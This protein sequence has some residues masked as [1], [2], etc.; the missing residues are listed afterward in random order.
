MNSNK[1][2]HISD[3]HFYNSD[4]QKSR[5]D[6]LSHFEIKK[7]NLK[8][9]ST[10]IEEMNIGAILISGD[11]ELD[12]CDSLY[13]FL[14]EWRQRGAKVFI[15]FGEHD[16]KVIR[17]D[18]EAKTE[19]LQGIY[20]IEEHIVID[21]KS[22]GFYV[23][24]LSC[25]SKQKDF[26]EDLDKVTTHL[27]IKPGVFLAHP[28]NITVQKMKEIGCKYYAVGHIHSS[29]IESYG[30][31]FKGRPGHLYSL[32]D[33]NGKAWPAR[34]VVGEF[35]EDKLKLSLIDFPSPQTVRL[36][37]NPY[38]ADGDWIP[39]I[40][41]NCTLHASEQLSELIPGEWKDEGFR[42]VYNGYYNSETEK[43][44]G[45]VREILKIFK[46]A[47]FVT[48]SDSRNMMK[49]YGYSRGVFR[50]KTLLNDHVLFEE[51]LERIPKAKSNTQ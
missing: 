9:V 37:T 32:W 44:E 25:G 41:E 50:A 17:R 11:L 3:L 6:G 28:N 1:F 39:V 33:G 13:Y 24:G 21:D 20:I 5:K 38:K 18:L 49:K 16:N 34:A 30:E 45:I 42:G 29:S 22:L 35:L 47:I 8:Y 40:I 14:I 26:A 51:F 7:Q 23:Q 46:E 2:L 43:L 19:S 31:L 4:H 48:P 36:F 12:N 15:V 27:S 10:L